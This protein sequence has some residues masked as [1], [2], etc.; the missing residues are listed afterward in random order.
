MNSKEKTEIF[1]K[2]DGKQNKRF[3]YFRETTTAKET[4][5]MQLLTSNKVRK[6]L[7]DDLFIYSFIYLFIYLFIYYQ[8]S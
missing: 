6:A 7:K 4:M 3:S 5:P 1:N 8:I 2:S